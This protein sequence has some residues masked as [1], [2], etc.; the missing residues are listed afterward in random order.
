[1]SEID[2]TKRRSHALLRGGPPNPENIPAGCA[3]HP[4]CPIAQDICRAEAPAFRPA[5]ASRAR[6]HFAGET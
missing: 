6:C 3:F 5:G 1:M 4:R 2:L